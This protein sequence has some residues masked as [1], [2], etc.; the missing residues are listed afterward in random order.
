[1]LASFAV[2]V[3]LARGLGVSGYGYYGIVLSIVTIAGIPVEL[4]IPRLVTREVA[5][6]DVEG[7][8]PRLFGI[9]KWADSIVWR[10]SAVMLAAIGIGAFVLASIRPPPLG[11][12]L[13]LGAPILPFM[14]LARLRGNTLQGL[15][16]ILRGQIPANLVRPLVLSL[17]LIMV[18]SYGTRVGPPLAAALT[19]I[20][21]AAAAVLAHFWLK[22]RLPKQR[23]TNF[24]KNGR[25]WIAS[26]IP[27]ALA[28]GM[29]VLQ[30]ELSTLL[31]GV[32]AAPATVGIFRIANV[33]AQMAAAAIPVVAHVAFPLV[34]RLHAEGDRRRLQRAITAFAAAQVAG[35]LL[36]S[37]PLL[38]APQFLLGLAFGEQFERA[39]IPV[40]ILIVGQIVN[41]VF[42][43]NVVLLYMTKHETRVTRALAIALALNVITVPL[44]AIF[45]GAIGASAALVISTAC[46]NLIAWR[47]AKRLVG[48]DTSL[49]F[50]LTQ[51]R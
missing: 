13:A 31:L 28:Q 3:Q 32:I 39:A 17:L 18:S 1:M 16:Y 21:A 36:L 15:R 11:V 29:R 26:S 27:M 10:F 43:P 41:S 25:A 40:L 7:D 2:G 8:L 34:A 6:A 42:G 35:V 47:D 33:T 46:W 9:L 37:L 5:A 30:I 23:P 51:G 4:G 24:I 14:A 50:V 38:I 49:S 45:A 20:S 19:S 48:I 12:A 44:L 22:K